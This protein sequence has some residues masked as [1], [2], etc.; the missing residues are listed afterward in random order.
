MALVVRAATVTPTPMIT[1]KTIGLVKSTRVHGDRNRR[2]VDGEQRE[3]AC[4]KRSRKQL[5]R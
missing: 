3:A 2:D 4:S 1:G 5:N